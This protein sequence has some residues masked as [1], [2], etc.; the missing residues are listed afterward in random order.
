M[1]R[2]DRIDIVCELRVITL[3]LDALICMVEDEQ[4]CNQILPRIGSICQ[5]LRSLRHSLI[6]HQIRESIFVI[7]KQHD[8]K[9][10]LRELSRLQDLFK[11][12]IH[13]HNSFNEVKA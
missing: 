6:A 10:Q 4:S 3:D 1:D 2:Q 13:I 8:A 7:Q 9:T 5:A 11:E 12:K